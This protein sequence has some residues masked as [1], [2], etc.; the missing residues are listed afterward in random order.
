MK[1]DKMSLIIPVQGQVHELNDKWL[2]ETVGDY[3]T[4]FVLDNHPEY[5]GLGDLLLNALILSV[6]LREKKLA[7]FAVVEQPA[8]GTL[9]EACSYHKLDGQSSAD[10]VSRQ[11]SKPQI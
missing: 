1:P 11:T 6:K 3:Q 4:L 2:A 9:K 7:I 5:E 8:H 10:R